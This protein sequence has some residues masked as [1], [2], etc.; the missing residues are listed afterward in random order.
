M[1]VEGNIQVI[2]DRRCRKDHG[3]LSNNY[4]YGTHLQIPG[5]NYYGVPVQINATLPCYL[6]IFG[7]CL[8]LIHTTIIYI[9]I[10]YI[11][12]CD[13]RRSKRYYYY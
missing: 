2:M 8:F 7:P 5:S 13:S 3:K 6:L 11:I 9:Y 10:L 1:G 12:I 4:S